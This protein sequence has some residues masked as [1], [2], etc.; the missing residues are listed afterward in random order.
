MITTLVAQ[1]VKRLPAMWETQVFYP[2]K[3][4]KLVSSAPNS[5]HSGPAQ[6]TCEGRAGP[7]NRIGVLTPE[8]RGT[9]LSQLQGTITSDLCLV[10]KVLPDHPLSAP[11]HSGCPLDFPERLWR[12]SVAGGFCKAHEPQ[13]PSPGHSSLGACSVWLMQNCSPALLGAQT[14]YQGQ[15]PPL[16][17]SK[18]P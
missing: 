1:R 11:H 13:F 12:V 15:I 5:S 16:R 8:G 17:R 4:S 9:G 18:V 7:K 6:S 2:Q 14:S 3:V 10:S